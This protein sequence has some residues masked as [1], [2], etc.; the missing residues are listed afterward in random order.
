MAFGGKLC[1]VVSVAWSS[2]FSSGM[3]LS[4]LFGS[5]LFS[6]VSSAASV[7]LVPVSLFVSR[8]E[9]FARSREQDFPFGPGALNSVSLVSVF[10]WSLGFDS[11]S[12]LLG[13]LRSVFVDLVKLV[14]GAESWE[15]EA[16]NGYPGNKGVLICSPSGDMKDPL[17]YPESRD[18]KG[19][20]GWTIGEGGNDG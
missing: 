18:V 17:K 7:S 2:L 4:S 16:I 11:F 13:F 20:G 19:S 10:S 14:D 1:P 15:W 5:C 9:F 3:L 12:S 6:F 8:V